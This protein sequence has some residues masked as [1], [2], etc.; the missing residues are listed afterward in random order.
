MHFFR[1]PD[2][3]LFREVIDRETHG[4][5]DEQA[6]RRPVQA[7]PARKPDERQGSDTRNDLGKAVDAETRH[8]L[9]HAPALGL[10]KRLRALLVD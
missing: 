7:R 8:D 3:P 9:V 10:G 2:R 6:D 4:G 1:V 5:K